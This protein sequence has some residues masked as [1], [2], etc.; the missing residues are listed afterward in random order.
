MFHWKTEQVVEDLKKIPGVKK[1]VAEGSGG[2]Y[3]TSHIVVSVEKGDKLFISGYEST[4]QTIGNVDDAQCPWV[5]VS[6]GQTSD[7]G[8]NS[9][10]AATGLVYIHVRQYFL[11]RGADVIDHYDQIF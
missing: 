4:E 1:V 9:T 8:L 10:K 5:E 6:D 2:D 3:D 11:D 7:G